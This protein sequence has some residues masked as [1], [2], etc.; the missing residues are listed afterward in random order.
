MERNWRKV[1]EDTNL[2]RWEKNDDAIYIFQYDEE[3]EYPKKAWKGF[4]VGIDIG[5]KAKYKHFKTELSALKFVKKY[6][7][8]Y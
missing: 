3:L 7:E 6:M 4:K 8:K 2:H 5:N 1:E